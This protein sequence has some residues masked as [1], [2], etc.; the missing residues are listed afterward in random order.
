MEKNGLKRT[1]HQGE[2]L[3]KP[4]KWTG[5][6]SLRTEHATHLVVQSHGSELTLLFFEYQP[7]FV[8]GTP[9][10]Q[11]D[12]IAKL[13]HVEAKCVAKIVMSAPNAA[14][15]SDVLSEQLSHFNSAVQEAI[16]IAKNS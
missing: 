3:P 1:N 15:A 9:E 6:E 12:Q 4:I 14:Q 7:P 8:T 10:E 2:H 13:P 5:Y 11:A 16:K